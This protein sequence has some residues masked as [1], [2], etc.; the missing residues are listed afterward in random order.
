M[1]IISAKKYLWKEWFCYLHSTYS[2]W[3]AG[4][5]LVHW[6]SPQHCHSWNGYVNIEK[7]QLLV[8]SPKRLRFHSVILLIR[9]R[10]VKKNPKHFTQKIYYE[11]GLCCLFFS[12]DRLH[13]LQEKHEQTE[14]RSHKRKSSCVYQNLFPLVN[15]CFL[16]PLHLARVQSRNPFY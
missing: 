15:L 8:S 13:W 7:S 1:T 14:R 6:G 3:Q 11:G 2:I 5:I 10:T 4:L 12:S 9:K 16:L